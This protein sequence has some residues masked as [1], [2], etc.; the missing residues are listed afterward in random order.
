MSN[1]T[2]PTW[3]KCIIQTLF[4]QLPRPSVSMENTKLLYTAGLCIKRWIP[5]GQSTLDV[6]QKHIMKNDPGDVPKS[7]VTVREHF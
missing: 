4:H 5:V 1:F 7:V 6:N 3:T 2:Q